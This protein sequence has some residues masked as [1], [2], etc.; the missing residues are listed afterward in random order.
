VDLFEGQAA[1]IAR[2]LTLLASNEASFAW[3]RK[4]FEGYYIKGSLEP[5]I[6]NCWDPGRVLDSLEWVYTILKSRED[7]FPRNYFVRKEGE[8][9][10][11]DD[12]FIYYQARPFRIF[13]RWAECEAVLDEPPEPHASGEDGAFRIPVVFRIELRG[14]KELPCRER[15]VRLEADGRRTDEL[16][17]D[18]VLHVESLSCF[19]YYKQ[20]LEEMMDLCRRAKEAGDLV[21][22]YLV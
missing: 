2:N 10:E 20:D 22:T 6:G 1:G 4:R 15:L 18:M 21:F 14:T 3:F 19:A 16:G 8:L 11:Y 7:Y 17:R 5:T 12:L 13:S 9:G